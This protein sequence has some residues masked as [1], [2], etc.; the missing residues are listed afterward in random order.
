MVQINANANGSQRYKQ[1]RRKEKILNGPQTAIDAVVCAWCK[2][3]SDLDPTPVEAVVI[4]P[5]VRK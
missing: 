4:D 5:Q 1:A 3:T 2:L